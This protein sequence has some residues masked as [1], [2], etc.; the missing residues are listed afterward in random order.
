MTDS[1][2]IIQKLEQQIAELRSAL[3]VK[4]NQ[5]SGDS[6]ATHRMVLDVFNALNIGVYRV[7]APGEGI[8]EFVNPA[9]VRLFGATSAEQL[10]KTPVINIYVDTKDR[11]HLYEKLQSQHEVQGYE[12][13]LRR[14]DGS[15]F[16]GQLS[17]IARF[18]GDG[19]ELKYVEGAIQDITD[20]KAT[21][22]A[23]QESERRLASIVGFLPDAT[24]AIDNTG[25]VVEWNMAMEEMT[26]VNAQEMIGKAEYEYAIP[27]YGE[28]R[29]ILIDLVSKPADGFLNK[30]DNIHW[31]GERLIGETYVPALRGKRAYMAGVAIA[32][33]NSDGQ[34]TGAIECIRDLSDRKFMEDK[35]LESERKLSSIIGFLPVPTF[36]IDTEGEIVAWN[37]ALEEMTG[38]KAEDMIGK[39]NHEYAIAFWGERRPILVDLVLNQNS[40]WLSR[41]GSIHWKGDTLYGEAYVPAMRGK[42]AF[43]IASAA[44]LKDSQGNIT[45]AIECVRD[46]TDRKI[47]EEEL[48]ASQKRLAEIIDFLPDDTFVIDTEGVIIAWNHSMEKTCGV[49]AADALGK[50]LIDLSCQIY[51]ERRPLLANLVL[52]KDI[53]YMSRYKNIRV[54]GDN[55]IGEGFA[56]LS[57]G[58]SMYFLATAAPLRNPQGQIV[59]VIEAVRDITALKKAEEER[60]TLQ[61][62]LAEAQRLE[63]I[64]R[65]A[66]GVAHDFNNLLTSI[67]GYAE[68]LHKALRPLDADKRVMV[69]QILK[70]GETAS[71]VTR[72]L[73]AFSRKQTLELKKINLNELII[74]FAK[75]LRRVI[76]EDIQL[77]TVLDSGIGMVKADQ[78]QIEQILLNLVVNARDAMPVGGCLTIETANVEL[79]EAYCSVHESLVPG[80]YVMLSVSDTGL[81]M[82]EETRAKI[83]EP[84]FTTKVGGKGTGL[85]LATV[86]GTVKQHN[87]HVVVFSEPGKG[88]TFRVYLPSLLDE[89]SK[90]AEKATK[91]V[92]QR[93]TETILLVEDDIPVRRLASRILSSLGYKVIEA[94]DEDDAGRIC[95]EVKEINL[96]LTDVVMPT[97]NGADLFEKISKIIPGIKVLFMS[98]YSFDVMIDRGISKDTQILQK[99]FREEELA[100]KVREI[101]DK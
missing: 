5:E 37:H 78:A 45:G 91:V 24:F 53:D 86:Y 6:I 55:L 1:K 40:E 95:S 56:E 51:K 25:K 81:G 73:L 77:R 11:E 66:G 35:L 96:L 74:N 68:M 4:L 27:F 34:I 32:L 38:F 13:R 97:M 57:N 75:V 9:M 44:V 80:S 83:F 10:L 98:G 54:E 48:E 46:I 39:G 90:P 60:Y 47:A 69:E 62:K 99:P 7:A 23:L 70:A 17:A 29:P 49:S 58:T 64:G 33:K 15:T 16:V 65:L 59:A 3:D 20:K 61:E 18:F 30:Y 85:G 43:V 28:R 12:I 79:N 19:N 52:N 2:E 100:R 89:A 42:R 41:Y 8:F 26:G 93:G 14:L 50:K 22:L 36:V 88:S 101:L 82:D 84:F 21:E 63:S 92:A 94:V 72:Q 71:S 67:L 76:G 31:E 87:G